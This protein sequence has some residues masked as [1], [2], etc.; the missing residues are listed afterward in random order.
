ME[1]EE[2]YGW[3]MEGEESYGWGGVIWAGHGGG[4]QP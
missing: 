2:S 4:S 3:G 1:G